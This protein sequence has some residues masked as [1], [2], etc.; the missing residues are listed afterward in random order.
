MHTLL[1][2]CAY[3]CKSECQHFAMR[4]SRGKERGKGQKGSVLCCYDGCSLTQEDPWKEYA[5]TPCSLVIDTRNLWGEDR[6]MSQMKGQHVSGGDGRGTVFSVATWL[7]VS[8]FPLWIT[9][10]VLHNP[11]CRPNGCVLPKFNGETN[12]MWWYVEVQSLGVILPWG[13]GPHE[14][15]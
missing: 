3:L 7:P 13:W 1:L 11:C 8:T 15:D 6:Q 12:P 2:A 10:I 4:I 14:W 5:S 9:G